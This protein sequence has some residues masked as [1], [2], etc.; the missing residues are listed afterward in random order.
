MRR[1]SSVA[2]AAAVGVAAVLSV[3]LD[4][5]VGVERYDHGFAASSLKSV[6][7]KLAGQFEK[8]PPRNEGERE[9]RRLLLIW[10]PNQFRRARRRV[11]LGRRGRT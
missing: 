2:T 11:R 3:M 6:F 9:L 8:G 1:R 10:S 7:G 5:T 4:D